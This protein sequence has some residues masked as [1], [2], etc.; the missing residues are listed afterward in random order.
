LTGI[1][2]SPQDYRNPRTW[3]DASRLLRQFLTWPREK[4]DGFAKSKTLGHGSK[5]KTKT[6]FDNFSDVEHSVG[7]QPLFDKRKQGVENAKKVSGRA[8]APLLPSFERS[9]PIN[10]DAGCLEKCT[11]ANRLQPSDAHMLDTGSSIKLRHRC[12]GAGAKPIFFDKL[13]TPPWCWCPGLPP[14][15]IV[16]LEP[17]SSAGSCSSWP[18]HC[19]N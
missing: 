5:L 2:E 12:L 1:P 8:I 16:P 15:G 18:H 4:L 7:R 14:P 9:C 13:R 11:K 6:D 3:F 17:A 10:V 19:G